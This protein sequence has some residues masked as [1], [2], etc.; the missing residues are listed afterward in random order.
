MSTSAERQKALRQRRT[1]QG[2]VQCNGWVHPHQYA[3]LQLLMKAL[4]D[5]PDLDA[6]PAID[7]GHRG[8]FTK[9]D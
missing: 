1:E 3:K 2:L 5:N 6:G 9:Y 8:R 7:R 4:L